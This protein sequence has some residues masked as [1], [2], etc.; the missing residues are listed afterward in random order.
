MGKRAASI[1]QRSVGP[2]RGCHRGLATLSLAVA[3]LAIGCAEDSATVEDSDEIQEPV[4]IR[5]IVDRAVATTGDLIT[6]RVHVD[7][8][9]AYEV[10]IPEAGAEVAGFRIVNVGQEEPQQRGGRI[11]QER[12]YQLRADLVG[13][14]VLP[15]LEV[16]YRPR[17][18]EDA[19]TG[20]W[21]T[22]VT[23]EIFVEVES[24]LPADGAA[25]DIRDLKPLREVRPGVH[26]MPIVAV[27]VGLALLGAGIVWYLRRR[28]SRR[29][30]L[31]PIPAHEL[32]F[33]ALNRLRQ[34]DFG[35]PEAVRWFYFEISE[36][37]R[38]YVEGRFR[39]NATD[40]TT[41][42]I[43]ASLTSLEEMAADQTRVLQGF[44]IDTDQVKFAHREPSLVDIEGTYEQAL[45]FVEATRPVPVVN[46]Q[47]KAA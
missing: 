36:V 39:L 24:V 27:V 46:M 25:T 9:A 16:R 18:A 7:S 34:T 15:P 23:S 45:G 41:E 29:D 12:W 5:A 21:Q 26:W 2:R 38:T 20:A 31:P 33:E 11:L 37:V 22:Q 32:A 35:N 4:A 3:F 47:E 1:E 40:L 8:D 42:E 10:E 17:A 28:A 6:Y 44:L 43:L 13:S 14:Y 19:E 30:S